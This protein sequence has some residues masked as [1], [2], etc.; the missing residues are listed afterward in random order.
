[1]T[2]RLIARSDANIG[3]QFKT[4]PDT[5][6]RT[7]A[8][9]VTPSGGSAHTQRYSKTVYALNTWYYIAGVYNAAAKTL[10]I[11]VNGVLDNGVLSGTVPSSQAISNV[12]TT[13][14]KRSGGYYFKGVIDNLRIYSRALSQADIQAD[15]NAPVTNSTR[16]QAAYS[17]VADVSNRGATGARL[18]HRPT[19]R[20]NLERHVRRSMRFPHSPARPAWPWQA[21]S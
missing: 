13:I 8:V 19:K 12:N 15:M 16:S 4:S 17:R 14:G 3:W 20:L 11:Y 10:D 2:V 9:A 1:M 6:V 18:R 7:F 21:A 5:G